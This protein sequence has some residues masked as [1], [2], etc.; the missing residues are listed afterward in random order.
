VWGGGRGFLMCPV[1]PH[2]PSYLFFSLSYCIIPCAA[3]LHE[4]PAGSTA[5]W[6]SEWCHINPC[7]VRSC[8]EV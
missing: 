8:A 2:P 7:A 5:A 4:S 1:K 6:E 3:L